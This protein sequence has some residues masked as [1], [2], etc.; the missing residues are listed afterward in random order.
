LTG[1]S[2]VEL[3]VT[4]ATYEARFDKGTWLGITSLSAQAL[5]GGQP[6]GREATSTKRVDRHNWWGYGTARSV[7]R[8]SLESALTGLLA[9]LHAAPAAAAR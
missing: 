1:D 2:P 4:I 7:L 3:R 9:Q 8:E 5:R 6:T